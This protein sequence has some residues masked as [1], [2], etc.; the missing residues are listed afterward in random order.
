MII[1]YVL[2]CLLVL[3]L[4]RTMNSSPKSAMSI[5]AARNFHPGRIWYEKPAPE[6]GADLCRRFLERVS[7][8]LDI[9]C[10]AWR[11]V[12]RYFQTADC[13]TKS[14][15]SPVFHIKRQRQK[16][17]IRWQ[18]CLRNTGVS[19][20]TGRGPVL[21]PIVRRYMQLTL[22]TCSQSSRG[23]TCP[24]SLAV[25]HTGRSVTRSPSRPELE[26]MPRPPSEQVA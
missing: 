1:A 5:F 8:V 9:D 12:R 2:M 21:D 17:N 14:L 19:S 24:P 26:A 18:D 3:I 15:Q 23:H 22:W 10:R 20:L 16:A 13:V 7:R 11:V 6:N 4:L 25:P